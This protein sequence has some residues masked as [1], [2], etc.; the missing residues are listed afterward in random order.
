MMN[1]F[2]LQE[3]LKDFSKEQLL[4]EMQA[5]SGNTPPFL[6]MTEL[7][8]R[9][10]MENAAALD[11]GPP[12]STVA[13]DTVNA[14]GVPQGGIADMARSL[15]PQTDMTQ[16]TGAMAGQGAAP[17]R[18][19][20]EGGLAGISRNVSDY[21]AESDP[22]IVTMA[23]RFGMSPEEYLA[24]LDPEARAQNM[25]RLERNRML[26]M[27][28][29]GDGAAFP[30][31]EDLDRRFREAPATSEMLT[32]RGIARGGVNPSF[33]ED[34]QGVPTYYPDVAVNSTMS[35]GVPTLTS[36]DEIAPYVAPA[37]ATGTV[38]DYQESLAALLEGR[39]VRP[40]PRP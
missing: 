17:V 6:V 5:P 8:R 7:Q 36:P 16:N 26:A 34:T 1:L 21:R 13:Q 39:P 24:S 27:E 31:Q 4:K 3:Q 23:G 38:E 10:R 35:R 30:T 22:A 11:K 29:V 32:E 25:R 20:Q 14:A 9:T 33:A 28:P 19:M 2:Q 40:S 18:A 37:G 15:A 12:T